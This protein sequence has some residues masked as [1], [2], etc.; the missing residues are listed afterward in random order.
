MYVLGLEQ[1]SAQAAAASAAATADGGVADAAAAA[2]AGTYRVV[3]SF[4]S[5]IVADV[6]GV[7]RPQEGLF[8]CDEHLMLYWL[9]FRFSVCHQQSLFVSDCDNVGCQSRSTSGC[10][11]AA[12]FLQWF[13]GVL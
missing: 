11:R 9:M 2:C 13:A 4:G 3:A 10:Y 1:L 5:V 6:R 12:V 8:R 7:C